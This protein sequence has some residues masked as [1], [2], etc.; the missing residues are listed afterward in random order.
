MQPDYDDLDDLDEGGFNWML[1]SVLLLAVTGFFALAWYAYQT[2]ASQV[3]VIKADATPVRARPENAG[4]REFLHQEKTIYEAINPEPSAP[5][6][7]TLQPAAQEPQLMSADEKVAEILQRAVSD[8]QKKAA[9]VKPAPVVVEAPK[10]APK[11]EPAPAP[12]AAALATSGERVQ[13]GAFRSKAEAEKNWQK[14][15]RA[16]GSLLKG[17]PHQVVRA[18]LGSKGVFYRLRVAGFND[19]DAAKALCKRLSAKGQGCFLV[20]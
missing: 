18:D 19:A 4:G 9:E 5:L 7:V 17:K 6:R 8:A 2:G 11:A 12:V 14:I 1:V 20:R 15:A 10:P 16:H 3:V 13:L